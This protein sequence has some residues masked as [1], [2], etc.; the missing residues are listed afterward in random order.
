M[1]T[2]LVLAI[3]HHVLAF[4]LVALL[5]GEAILVRP[6]MTGR[7]IDR[8]AR[9]DAAYG[10]TSGAIIIVG[11]LR[12][13]LGI[14]GVDYYLGN[15]WFWAKMAAFVVV[16]ALSILPT[17]RFARWRRARAADPAF[18][19]PHDDILAAQRMLRLESLV[20]VLVLVFAATMARYA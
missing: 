20:L 6:G 2:D 7:D 3:L 17:M 14:K 8:A 5:M 16:G 15:P 11:V 10:I 19:P 18:L 12:V 1:F 4:G 9:I 13:F